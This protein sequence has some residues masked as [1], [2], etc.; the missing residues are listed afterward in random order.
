MGEFKTK[1]CNLWL[2]AKGGWLNLEQWKKCGGEVNLELLKTVP[3]YAGLDLAS[4]SDITAWVIIWLYDDIVSAL[5]KFYLPEDT[6]EPRTKKANLPYMAWVQQGYLTQTPGNVTDYNHIK[7]DI[8]ADLDLFNIKEIGYDPWNATQTVNDLVDDGAPMVE[9]RQGAKTFHPPMQELERL[10]KSEKL[11]HG[12]NPVLSWMASNIVARR[13]VNNN[14]APDKKNS[15][16]KI[17]GIV[18]LLMALGRL[19][20]QED[21]TSIYES[22]GVLTFGG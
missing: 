13:D 12:N 11:C 18:A 16:E 10:L 4:V 8:K 9:M 21:T 1:R 7:K 5:C 20:L 22:R 15:M 19:I 17:D 14:M 6:I 3:A 2:S